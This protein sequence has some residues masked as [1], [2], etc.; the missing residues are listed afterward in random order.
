[1]TFQG[2]HLGFPKRP[3]LPNSMYI[4]TRGEPLQDGVGDLLLI[5]IAVF[6]IFYESRAFLT[7]A[8]HGSQ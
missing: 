6:G 1:M 5:G 4:V 2:L 3:Y 8:R 7:I